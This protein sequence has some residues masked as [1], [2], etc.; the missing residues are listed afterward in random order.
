MIVLQSGPGGG[1]TVRLYLPRYEGPV[2]SEDQTSEQN[3]SADAADDEV[4]LVVEDN[5]D[6]RKLVTRLLVSLGYRVLEAESARSAL[7]LLRTDKT[8]DLLLSDIVMPGGMSGPGLY[9]E[10]AQIRP[11]LPVLFM[12]GYAESAAVGGS[13]IG[14]EL[15][16]LRK[17]FRRG[18]IAEAVR[19]ALR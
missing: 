8:V 4:V 7:D 11:G 9:D 12:S 3:F 2:V 6:L 19:S 16:L 15:P 10:A 5:E 14:R 13:R 18:E 17:P 1:T